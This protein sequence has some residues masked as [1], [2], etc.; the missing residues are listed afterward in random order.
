MAFIRVSHASVLVYWKQNSSP[1]K[2]ELQLSLYNTTLPKFLSHFWRYNSIS[3]HQRIC[4]FSFSVV[5]MTKNTDITYPTWA[6]F[7]LGD[8]TCLDRFAVPNPSTVSSHSNSAQHHGG[9]SLNS[10]SYDENLRPHHLGSVCREFTS[11]LASI[12]NL[13]LSA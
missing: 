5:N 11:G 6:D 4:Q 13:H 1:L 9:P 10:S 2:E 7:T 8:E 3:S 12:T